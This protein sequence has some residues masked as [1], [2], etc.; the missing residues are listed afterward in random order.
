[1]KHKHYFKP[2]PFNHIDIYRVIRLF[3]IND[4]CLQHALK[5]IMV[6]GGRGSK[7]G[8]QDIQ[9]AIDSLN[10]YL[11]MMAEDIQSK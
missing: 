8:S 4:P 1:M 3:E 2:C 9:E 7:T 5:K 6:S 11:D 10:R